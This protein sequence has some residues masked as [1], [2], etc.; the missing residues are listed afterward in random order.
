MSL[1]MPAEFG[2]HERTV[3]C[4]PSRADLYGD[5]MPEARTAHARVARAVTEFEPV[6]MIARAGADAADAH[7]QCGGA[8]D[9]VELPL[10]DSWFR[11]TG[12]IYVTAPGRRVA[13][14][15]TF[16]GWGEKFE[17]FDS[18]AALARRWG[19]HAGHEVRTVPM[20]LEGGSLT[21][22]GEGT[23]VT[24]AQCLLHPNRNSHLSRTAIEATLQ[25]ELGVAVV[26][27]LPFGLF[28]D[29]DTDGHVDNVA[30]YARPGVLLLQG[31]DDP[32][33]PDHDRMSANRRWV[34]GA[35]DA[36]GRPIEVIEVP[37]LPFGEIG[38]RRVPVPYLNLYVGNGFVLVPVCG[39]PADTDMCAIIG[40]QYPG[41]QV[42]ALDVGA[43]L[44]F[45]GGGIHCITQQVPIVPDPA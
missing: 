41:R 14:D 24:T 36:A 37:V 17:P 26:H 6:T 31:C 11:D 8:V 12:P 39:H 7:E 30:A 2:P 42:V 9:V 18:D 40:Q 25:A 35:S 20:V 27:W 19:E 32:D 5:L 13:T 21:V 43:V 33:L 34:D 28:D 15:W 23:L 29:H 45:G 38:G 1:G 10:D 22:D 4:W 44:A 3:I 16:N